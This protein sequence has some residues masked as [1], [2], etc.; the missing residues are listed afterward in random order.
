[1]KSSCET[2]LTTQA[3]ETLTAFKKRSYRLF[4]CDAEVNTLMTQKKQY[5]TIKGT[6]EGLIFLLDDSCSYES[7]I[8]ELQEKLSSKHYQ[9][10]EGRD[11]L[12]KVDIGYRY[13]QMK[14]KEELEQ[15]ITDGRNLAVEQ[16]ESHV[17]S[18]KEAEQLRQES[19][20][21]TLTRIIRSGQ[22]LKVNG[23]VLLI[24]DVNPGGTIVATGNIYIMGALRGIAHAGFQGNER[25]IIAASLMAPAQLRI[26]E[27]MKQFQADE[28]MEQ[29]MASAYLDER[30]SLQIGRVQ[31]L[32]HSHP[33]LATNEKQLLD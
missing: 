7:L 1:M 8:E 6:K 24:G 9:N 11:I 5:V 22:V 12:V 30:V 31:Q 17:I 28:E 21:V 26:A 19:Q 18:K 2:L 20:M 14:Q 27:G 23:D 3:T 33:Q 29:L 13:L 25:A 4:L 32:V 15:I 10:S 16:F